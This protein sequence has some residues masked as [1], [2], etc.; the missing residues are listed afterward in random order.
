MSYPVEL[1]LV[2]FLPLPHSERTDGSPT[3]RSGPSPPFPLLTPM[4]QLT[5][6]IKYINEA[7]EGVAPLHKKSQPRGLAPEGRS[8][9]QPRPI[10]S[11]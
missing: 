8:P 2:L 3:A 5:Y 4:T 1:V 7:I 6:S 11:D 10:P 9:I